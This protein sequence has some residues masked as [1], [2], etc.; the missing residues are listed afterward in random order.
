MKTTILEKVEQI[1]NDRIDLLN[2]LAE[3]DEDKLNCKPASGKWSVL[4]IINHLIISEK[5]SVI[6]IKRKLSGKNGL[7]KAT[8][9]SKI[10]AFVL[11][12]GLLLPLK[13]KA[14]ENV[15]NLPD[16]DSFENIKQNWDKVRKSFVSIIIDL[17]DDMLDKDIFKHPTVGK[18]NIEGAIDFF[19]SH[20]KHHRKQI[21]SLLTK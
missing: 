4:Q 21:Y 14:P 17:P 2:K 5:L 20:F 12:Y 10:N 18:M 13:L 11:R 15:S 1:E 8:L 7:G 6:Y 3:Y 19:D 16:Y 9:K